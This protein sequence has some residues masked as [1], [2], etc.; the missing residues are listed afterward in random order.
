M[1][2]EQSQVIRQWAEKAS[3][4]L[5]LAEHALTMQKDQCPF[6]LI[7]FHA[8]QA[9]EKYLKTL[10][11]LRGVTVPRTHDLAELA[12]ILPKDIALGVSAEAI[13]SLT[14]YA[15]QSRYPGIGNPEDYDEAVQALGV[16]RQLKEVVDR[17]LS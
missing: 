12:G 15:V 2:P 8:Q 4:D 5:L 1:S 13:A 9:V 10:L 6:D 7:C 16:A 11:I 14:P 3:R 17:Q